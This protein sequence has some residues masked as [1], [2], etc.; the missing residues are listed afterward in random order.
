VKMRQAKKAVTSSTNRRSDAWPSRLGF[1]HNQD[2]QEGG[3]RWWD[4]AASAANDK[5]AAWPA[6]AGQK[7]NHSPQGPAGA[8]P[9]KLFIQGAW[10]NRYW[11]SQTQRFYPSSRRGPDRIACQ[12]PSAQK[13]QSPR[14]KPG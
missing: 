10:L 4:Q 11:S 2:P 8:V 6:W 1:C 12:P 3:Q 14:P 5:P 7:I 13:R 9:K